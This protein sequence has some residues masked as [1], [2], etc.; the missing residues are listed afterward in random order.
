MAIFEL[1]RFQLLPAS[2]QQQ[3]LFQKTL[4]ADQI[5]AHK[6]D[7]LD[8]AL[9][10]HLHFRHRGLE[11]RHKVEL[12]DGPW[13]MFKIGAHKSVDRDTEDFRRERIESWP[14]VTV[15]LHNDPETQIIAISRNIKAFSSTT[16]V[17]KLFER[18]LASALRLYG[19]TV[20]VREQF[21]KNN[22]WSVVEGNQGKVSRVRFEMVA[23]N[24]ANI[25]R[26]LK[27]DLRQ[28]NRDSNCQK[29]N[30]ELEALPGTALE[31]NPANELVDGCVE[32]SSQGGGDIAIK[33]RG[34][35]KEI[36]TSTTVKS[37]EIDE[38]LIKS[39]NEQLLSLINR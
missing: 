19:L 11:V 7:F 22:F 27:V 29:A 9:S 5:R 21:E 32:Y 1:F 26:V 18:A 30:L 39:P 38:S 34:I 15:I 10:E 25:S 8:A 23:P 33:I 3:D 20:Q 2:Q 13:F 28:L 36:R 24:M 37:V 35:N 17:S 6:N 14:N 4:S 16:V 12:H 31:I